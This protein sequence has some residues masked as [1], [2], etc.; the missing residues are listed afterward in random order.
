MLLC[1]LHS[2]IYIYTDT[3]LYPLTEQIQT[4]CLFSTHNF[5][6]PSPPQ[7]VATNKK[8]D[9][10]FNCTKWEREESRFIGQ[11]KSFDS[12]LVPRNSSSGLIY[13]YLQRIDYASLERSFLYTIFFFKKKDSH[14]AQFSGSHFSRP[15]CREAQTHLLSSILLAFDFAK[16]PEHM[17]F[18]LLAAFP[19]VDVIFFPI[20]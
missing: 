12:S 3:T 4:C 16:V 6:F 2:R 5:I 17:R 7:Q 9:Q 8:V 19:S 1:G 20:E 13:Y 15:A 10:P 18:D 11:K 14:P